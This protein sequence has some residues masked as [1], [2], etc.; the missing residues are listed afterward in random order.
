MTRVLG[1]LR[2]SDPDRGSAEHRCAGIDLAVGPIR[3]LEHYDPSLLRI[4]NSITSMTS[5]FLASVCRRATWAR[6]AEFF[7]PSDIVPQGSEPGGIPPGVRS[8]VECDARSEGRGL[9]SQAW[10]YAASSRS[11]SVLRPSEL[12]AAFPARCMESK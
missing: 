5:R 9:S 4:R 8:D 2:Y 1:G 3:R 11:N 7:I 10:T 6:M 12:P